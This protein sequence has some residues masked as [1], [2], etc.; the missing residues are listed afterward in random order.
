ME[1]CLFYVEL[2]FVF[3]CFEIYE[4]VKKVFNKVCEIL[5]KDLIIW[6]MVVKFEE[7]YGNILMV[8]KIL[9]RV[10]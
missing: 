6:I 1:C 10:I 2:W 5:L 8:G 3:V 7:V 9:E 4:N